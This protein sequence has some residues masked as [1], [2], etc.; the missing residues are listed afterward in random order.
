MRGM[1]DYIDIK[2]CVIIGEGEKDEA[3]MLY[4]GEIVGMQHSDSMEVDIAVDP[5]DGTT[6]TAKRHGQRPFRS[7]PWAS[8]D[9]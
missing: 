5:V 8:G 9:P 4:C 1:L 3:P 6:M 7:S 2:G